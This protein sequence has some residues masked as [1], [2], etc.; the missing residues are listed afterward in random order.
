MNTRFGTTKKMQICTHTTST[1]T[2]TDQIYKVVTNQRIDS[3]AKYFEFEFCI[4]KYCK[5]WQLQKS[6]NK[7]A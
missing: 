2:H 7:C 3:K 6:E 1:D 5:S 4:V